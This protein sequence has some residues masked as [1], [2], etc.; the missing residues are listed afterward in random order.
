MS[1]DG[2]GSWPT[3]GD[4][5]ETMMLGEECAVEEAPYDEER[6][7]WESVPNTVVTIL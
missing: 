6:R 1:S 2:L 4:K 7:A 5:R 3:Y